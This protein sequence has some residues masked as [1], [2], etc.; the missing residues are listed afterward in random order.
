MTLVTKPFDASK[1]L[2]GP[3]DYAEL[4]NDA[5]ASGHAGYIAATL[6]T[7]ARAYGVAKLAEQTGL[8]RATIYA[9]LSPDGNPTLDTVLKV[10]SSLGVQLSAGRV[11]A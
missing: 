11:P 9:A 7:A 6:G 3:E 5:L 10:S 4:I 1:Y 2:D 8:N